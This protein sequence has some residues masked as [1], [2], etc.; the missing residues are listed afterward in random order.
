[1][2]FE[3]RDRRLANQLKSANQVG[4]RHAVIFGPQEVE[5]GQARIRD[6]ASGDERLVGIDQLVQ[7]LGNQ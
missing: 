4:A 1:V 2:V 7:E 5:A 6:M 3:Y